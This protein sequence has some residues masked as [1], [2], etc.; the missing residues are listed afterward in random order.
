MMA[1]L[2]LLQT[3]SKYVSETISIDLTELGGKEEVDTPAK[4]L[5]PDDLDSLPIDPLPEID[6]GMRLLVAACMADLPVH[7]PRIAALERH[8]AEA[9][10]AR[11]PE[12]YRDRQ[13]ETDKAISQIIQSCIFDAQMT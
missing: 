7:R 12:Q 11:R 6:R 4:N 3:G 1:T 5:L 13:I 9:T 8:V 2:M 10:N